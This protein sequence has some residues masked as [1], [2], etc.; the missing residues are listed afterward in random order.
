MP[1]I[2]RRQTI[3]LALS[4]DI[5]GRNALILS[6]VPLSDLIRDLNLRIAGEFSDAVT[7]ADDIAVL[8]PG[9]SLLDAAET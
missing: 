1:N 6:I 8:F 9:Q 3:P 5:L 7:R 2:P 4:L